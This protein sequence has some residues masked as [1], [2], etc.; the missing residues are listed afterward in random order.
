MEDSGV[1]G[2]EYCP[3]CEPTTDPLAE[4]VTVRFCGEHELAYCGTEDGRVTV[5]NISP[6]GGVDGADGGDC[7]EFGAWLAGR[8]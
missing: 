4:V 6:G 1:V 5:H 7:R 8:R 2:R 3:A